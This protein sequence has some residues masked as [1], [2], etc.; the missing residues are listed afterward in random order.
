MA[1]H[2]W[3]RIAY[4][5][6]SRFLPL[7]TWCWRKMPSKVN[8]KR[9][10]AL[11]DAALR[12]VALPLEAPV[13]EIVERVAR[14]QEDRLGRLARPLQA[15]PE[16]DVPDLDDAVLGGDAQVARHAAGAPVT[17]VDDRVE[18]RILGRG[19]RLELRRQRRLVRDTGRTAGSRQI[20]GLAGGDEEA[21][22][23]AARIDRLEPHERS[24]DRRSMR[25]VG[26]GSSAASASASR[27]SE[28]LLAQSVSGQTL[29]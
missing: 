20:A 6:V 19:V 16:P 27:S 1:G 29:V 24:L 21:D 23:V 8:P 3:S 17:E 9:S 10:A 13:A 26:P 11:R 14:E 4:Q 28:P 5:A 22:L 18:Q 25:A 15:Q 7:T 2:S 12:G